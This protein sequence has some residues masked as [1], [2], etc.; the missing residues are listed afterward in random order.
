MRACL[1]CVGLGLL[2]IWCSSVRGVLR[3]DIVV[4]ELP[5]SRVSTRAY[6]GARAGIRPPRDR[7]TEMVNWPSL[8]GKWKT[9]S[10]HGMCAGGQTVKLR[11]RSKLQP[12]RDTVVDFVFRVSSFQMRT[13]TTCILMTWMKLRVGM[14]IKQ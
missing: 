3:Q 10:L 4:V 2:P 5:V 6:D 12:H 7:G 1:F 13:S 11:R 14:D 8:G 9:S